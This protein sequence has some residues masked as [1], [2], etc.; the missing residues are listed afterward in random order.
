MLGT[1]PLFLFLIL[2]FLIVTWSLVLPYL[3]FPPAFSSRS[4]EGRVL[5]S[6]TRPCFPPRAARPHGWWR[7]GLTFRVEVVYG[8]YKDRHSGVALSC[9]WGEHIWRGKTASLLV[10]FPHSQPKLQQGAK[11]A[12][13]SCVF[14][15]SF[16]YIQFTVMIVMEPMESGDSTWETLNRQHSISVL[17][18]YQQGSPRGASLLSRGRVPHACPRRRRKS[19]RRAQ[20]YRWIFA[21]PTV[22]WLFH[23]GTRHLAQWRSICIV[24][25]RSWVWSLTLKKK[26]RISPWTFLG[27]RLWK[28]PMQRGE[29]LACRVTS[30]PILV[31]NPGMLKCGCLTGWVFQSWV[32]AWP[33]DHS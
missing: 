31:S 21:L 12:S 30:R 32:H 1:S 17:K 20:G 10:S 18:P 14:F 28:W 2:E 3:I 25:P 15:C 9:Q 13:W 16:L 4:F 23:P 6:A 29:G 26:K 24:C 5:V 22:P 8:P 33:Q 19:W 11:V 7:R 27:V